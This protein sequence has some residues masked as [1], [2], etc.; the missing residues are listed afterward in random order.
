MRWELRVHTLT[1]GK[2]LPVV[3]YGFIF[4]GDSGVGGNPTA[5]TQVSWGT[6]GTGYGDTQTAA[7]LNNTTLGTDVLIRIQRDTG[8]INCSSSSL[9]CYTVEICSTTGGHCQT[10]IGNVTNLVTSWP[11]GAQFKINPGA[12]VAFLRWYSTVIPIGTPVSIPANPAGDLGDWEFEGN[13]NDSSGHGHNFSGGSTQFVSTPQYAPYCNPGSQQSFRAGYSGNLDGSGSRP[14]DE[15]TTLTYLWE[16]LPGVSPTTVTWLTLQAV[17]QPS[18][19]NLA[20]GSYNF[21]LTVTDGSGHSTP[22]TIHDGAVVTDDNSV[23]ALSGVPITAALLGPSIQWSHN[24]WPWMDDRDVAMA[25]AQMNNIDNVFVD[26]WSANASGTIRL[27][28]GSAAVTGVGT[29]FTTD[30]C[31][32]S[33]NPTTAQP[34]LM[35]IAHWNAGKN[36]RGLFAASCTDDTH[37][38]LNSS[39]SWNLPNQTNITYGIDR[40]NA[41]KTW[42]IAQ[43]SAPANYYDNVAGLYGLYYRTGIDTYLSYARTWADRFWQS[44]MMDQGWSDTPLNKTSSQLC[45]AGR[46]MSVL[47]MVLRAVDQ[48]QIAGSPGS[49]AM[50]AGLH[51]IWTQDMYVATPSGGWIGWGLPGMWD[52]R[53]QALNTMRVALCALYDPTV[54]YKASCKA[55][56]AANF[57]AL[58]QSVHDHFGD[59]SFPGWN[60]NVGSPHDA[61]IGSPLASVTATHGSNVITLN[62]GTWTQTTF[63][64]KSGV[65]FDHIHI[66]MWDGNPTVRPQLNSEGDQITYTATYQDSRHAVLTDRYGNAT[67]YQGTTGTKGW[68]GT[69]GDVPIMGWAVQPFML[70]IISSA[71]DLASQAMQDEDYNLGLA[72]SFRAYAAGANQYLVTSGYR[73]STKGMYY[74]VGG[75]DCPAGAIVEDYTVCTGSGTPSAPSASRILSAEAVRGMMFNWFNNG[76]DPALKSWIDLLVNAEFA[77]PGTCPPASTVCVADGYYLDQIDT[78]G[79]FMTGPIPAPKWFGM[80]FGFNPQPD[81]PAMRLSLSRQ[82]GKVRVPAQKTQKAA[83]AF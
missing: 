38:T 23:V 28:N 13:L 45:Y 3:N 67:T 73:P 1:P 31:E 69:V 52:Q 79:A 60:G 2:G 80:T 64:G 39:Y 46:S 44:P 43:N 81:W 18:I 42:G 48:D 53:E 4:L 50:W 47:G 36:N 6:M 37:L 71:F 24:P 78:G 74:L 82:N 15:G 30:I 76:H 10:N 54:T 11:Y 32:G 22:C 34:N 49:S 65:K 21:K 27:V 9:G 72:Q 5:A 77:K 59:Y 8:K 41:W 56:L 12:D 51:M 58:W 62:S 63:A 35:F 68:A 83:H 29:H 14:L 61:G 33:A 16:Q 25:A 20:F 57:T 26:F 17:A 75:V 70:G 66:W 40:N 7:V 55:A 19:S